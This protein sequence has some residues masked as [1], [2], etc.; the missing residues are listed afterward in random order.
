MDAPK[1]LLLYKV[2][3]ISLPSVP[4]HLHASQ[5][6]SMCWQLWRDDIPVPRRKEEW[7]RL[8]NAIE[9]VGD[10]EYG[11]TIR[12]EISTQ[13]LLFSMQWRLIPLITYRRYW[14]SLLLIGPSSNFKVIQADTKRVSIHRLQKRDKNDTKFSE[15]GSNLRVDRKSDKHQMR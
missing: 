11:A 4:G 8:Q 7:I 3:Q 2:V 9:C 15:T 10:I 13:E 12:L 6:L 1:S 14:S 5:I